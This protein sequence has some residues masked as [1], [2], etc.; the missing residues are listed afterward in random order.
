M[1]ILERGLNGS[2]QKVS[3]LSTS[4]HPYLATFPPLS[5]FA[6]ENPLQPLSRL[7]LRLRRSRGTLHDDPSAFGLMIPSSQSVL[8]ASV[9]KKPRYL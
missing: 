1:K 2:Y 6:R 5:C 4:N 9:L 8:R 3:L 7:S